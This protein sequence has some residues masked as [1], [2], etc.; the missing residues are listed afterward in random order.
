MEYNK[1][2]YLQTVR[3]FSDVEMGNIIGFSGPGYADMIA[4]RRLRVD[5]LEKFAAY[6]KKPI[7]WF[8]EPLKSEL[9]ESA[10]PDTTKCQN[11]DCILE[12]EKSQ[13]TI[14]DLNRQNRE[15]L[16]TIHLLSRKVPGGMGEFEGGVAQERDAG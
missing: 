10:S 4:A 6:F 15:M 5:A 12:R 14:E 7:N 9:E 2:R 13:L 11:P 16:K 3:R 8:F 1:L